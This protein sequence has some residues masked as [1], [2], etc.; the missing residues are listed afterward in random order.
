MSKIAVNCRKLPF[1]STL[2]VAHFVLNL[3]QALAVDHEIVFIVPDEQDFV[4]SGAAR[5]VGDFGADVLSV[6]DARKS[7]SHLERQYIELLPHHFQEPE[8]CARSILICHDLHVF[9][10]PWKYGDRA[11]HMQSNFRSVV[12]AAS[13]VVTHFPRT[14][15]D[16]ERI[17]GLKLMNLFLTESPLLL[18]TSVVF[19]ADVDRGDG[20]TVLLYPAQLQQH[21]N[22]RTLIEALSQRSSGEPV[23]VLCPGSDFDEESSADLRR[24]AAEQVGDALQFLGRVTDEELVDLYR[25]CDAVIVPSLAEGGALVALEGI[26]AGK[27]VAVNDIRSARTHLSSVGA[28]VL[29]FDAESADDTLRAVEQLSSEDAAAALGANRRCRERLRESTWESLGRTW[30]ELIAWLDGDRPRPT[31]VVNRDL[32]EIALV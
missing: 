31:V 17:A 4:D 9:D 13:A 11:A 18:D 8:H 27:P 29:W 15:Y 19:G 25:T 6:A 12:G 2:G 21:K 28:D 30:S 10:I 20:R 32:T 3:T 23:V 22:H 26:A 7:R 16:V 14:Y 5:V 1:G 24:S